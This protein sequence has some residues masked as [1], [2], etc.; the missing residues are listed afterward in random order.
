MTIQSLFEVFHR[1]L[2]LYNLPASSV[3]DHYCSNAT[4]G[5]QN[6]E[7]YYACLSIEGNTTFNFELELIDVRIKIAEWKFQAAKHKNK[8]LEFNTH[9][10]PYGMWIDGMT[11][12]NKSIC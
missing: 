11:H 10:L 6:K 2:K 4:N 7:V 12:W 5:A 1:K 9:L 3:Q 8:Y